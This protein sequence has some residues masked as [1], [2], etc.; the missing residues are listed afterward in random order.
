MK[1]ILKAQI[2][3][4]PPNQRKGSTKD[5]SRGFSKKEPKRQK[6]DKALTCFHCQKLGH[7][8]KDC[9]KYHPWRQK[10]DNL[11]THVYT[12]VNLASVSTDTWCL[13]FGATIHVSTSMQGCLHCRKPISEE[14]Y[15]FTGNETSARV[16]GIGT[17]RFVR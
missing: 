1:S 15:V 17:F 12:E 6:H 10:K 7:F 4:V 3:V 9:A 11:I 2:L 8:K 5:Q 16:E 14:K 13:D